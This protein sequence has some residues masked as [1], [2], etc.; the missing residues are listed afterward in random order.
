MDAAKSTLFAGRRHG[1]VHSY[2]AKICTAPGFLDSEED[3]AVIVGALA[4]F[5][6][7][8]ETAISGD[9]QIAA[10]LVKSPL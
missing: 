6:Q 8:R 10:P 4:S 9:T 7:R 3:A 1:P 2:R 5:Q